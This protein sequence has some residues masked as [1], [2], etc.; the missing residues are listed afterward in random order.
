MEVLKEGMVLANTYEIMEEIGSGGGGIVF[1]ARHMRMNVDVVV[2]KIRAEIQGK[3]NVRKE[4]DILKNLK[5]Q[6]LPKVYDFIERED[7]VYTVMD[8]VQ[9]ENMEEA[10]HKNGRYPQRQVLKWA[11]Q[12][13]EALAYLHAQNPP[14]IHSDIK[15]ANVMLTP[16]GDVCLIDFNISLAMGQD[17][18]KVVGISAG[19]SPPEQYPRIEQY[20]LMRRQN[21]KQ[22]PDCR[23]ISNEIKKKQRVT[24]I[25]E[26][27][28]VR[29]TSIKEQN[30]QEEKANEEKNDHDIATKRRTRHID[31]L[32]TFVLF[33]AEK[34]DVQT[35]QLLTYEEWK[36]KEQPEYEKYIGQNIDER[37]DIY[38]LGMTLYTLLLGKEPSVDFSQR[39][40][41]DIINGSISEGLRLVLEKMTMLSPGERYQNGLQYLNA[42]KNCYKLDQRY[43]HVQRI[44]QW[45]QTAALACLCT[46][47]LVS[48]VGVNHIKK[49]NNAFYYN[50]LQ[51][52]QE[53]MGEHDYQNAEAILAGAKEV[54]KQRI[55]AY[56]LEVYLQY[57]MG[58]FQ[59]CIEK[60]ELYINTYPF[61][62]E[63]EGDK[64]LLGNM[65][66]IVGN[67]YF[68]QNDYPA[69]KNMFEVAIELNDKNALI[70]RDNAITTAKLKQTEEAKACLQRG[71]E[72]GL[73]EDSIYMVQGEIA[74]MEG[75]YQ[76]AEQFLQ[77]TIQTTSELQKKNRAVL[78]CKDVYRNMGS[79][80]IDAEIKLL[81]QYTGTFER[82][83]DFAI[84]E[85]LADAY[86]R[87]A[88][89]DKQEEDYYWNK[90]LDMFLYLREQGYVTFQLQENLAILYENMDN[91]NMAEEL[92]I[93]LTKSYPDRYEVYKRL[94][95]LE[96][97]RQQMKENN[98]REYGQMEVY[99]NK[100]V[101]LYDESL[102]DIEM[103]T[104]EIMMQEVIEAGWL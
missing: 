64:E 74:Y 31:L 14:I 7:G 24:A 62:L 93:E 50:M 11:E 79:D 52:A 58:D 6:Y 84:R 54:L 80:K 46:G 22:D 44:E 48:V 53:K 29:Y 83:Y 40:S 86:V 42:V 81:E 57:L 100:A 39:Y 96:A 94:A 68:E 97:D 91:F 101:E 9:G 18:D 34:K 36:T 38:S 55:E 5:H 27:E 75:D 23:E 10:L 32:S 19:F 47:I 25:K 87:K 16:K 2:K 98:D 28:I 26:Q 15:P 88:K 3:V 73:S 103:Q 4:A 33:A 63:T 72:L 95:Y 65:Y 43:I 89:S 17:A 69:A 85:S 92:L 41:T 70:F 71:I 51:D 13:G 35:Q 21:I 45:I 90:A 49:E 60:G 56:E 66:Y 82:G 30:S 37:S 102:N 8:F 1:K 76:Q 77:N 12:L 99:Y 59:A 104:L 20:D 61:V 67:A 78:L